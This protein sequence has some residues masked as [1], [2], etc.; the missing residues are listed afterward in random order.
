M[1][2]ERFTKLADKFSDNFDT[3]YERVGIAKDVGGLAQW[4]GVLV[5]EVDRLRAEVKRLKG[6]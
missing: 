4:V 6:E 2:K 1:H 3:V 5:A